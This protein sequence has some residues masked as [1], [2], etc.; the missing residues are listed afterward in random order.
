MGDV[1]TV[2]GRACS[3]RAQ[4]RDEGRVCMWWIERGWPEDKRRDC[5]PP[6]CGYRVAPVLVEPLDVLRAGGCVGEADEVE[7]GC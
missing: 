6:A 4:A 2:S 3:A 5:I 1:G 7:T